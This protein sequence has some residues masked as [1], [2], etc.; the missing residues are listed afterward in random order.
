MRSLPI[1]FLLFCLMPTLGWCDRPTNWESDLDYYYDQ[2]TSRHISPFTQISQSEFKA[3]LSDIKNQIEHSSD[4]EITLALMR[5]TR[6]IGDGHTAVQFS[7]N[8]QVK[9]FP[10]K[11]YDDQGTWRVIAITPAHEALLGGTLTHING[12]P[13]GEIKPAIADIAQYV[14][15][16]QSLTQRI[17][18]YARY[19]DILRALAFIE[20]T[21]TTN[22]VI[23]LNGESTTVSLNANESIPDLSTFVPL[24][25]VINRVKQ[26]DIDG[27]WF[28][29]AHDHQ[30]I[31]I[32]FVHYP[33][34][35][36]MES[37]GS[38]LL[39][40]IN[41]YQSQRL[42]ID[43][44]GNGGGDLFVGL[45]LAYV[46]NLA[47]SVDWLNGVYT[48]IDND[49][50]SAATINATQYRQLLNARIIGQTSGSNPTGFQDMDTFQLPH[51][52]L[53]ISYSKRRFRLQE[54]AFSGLQ[55]DNVVPYQWRDYIKGNDT[56]LQWVLDDITSHPHSN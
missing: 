53:T 26:S 37:F 51:S 32:K 50:F 10:L 40:H 3:R 20:K 18:Q 17:V 49:T 4:V 33:S 15:N 13:I 8:R 38:E 14:E 23:S 29:D 54:K 24:T 2:M 56:Q 47:D 55:P 44:R 7:S 39:N 11:L 21:D 36:Q 46:L 5:L 42:I 31:Y 41:R 25:P 27:L 43:M 16:Q 48:L 52:M 12:H 34:Y 30:T 6:A 19:A 28:G 22:F 45:G 9:Q 1:S 35:E